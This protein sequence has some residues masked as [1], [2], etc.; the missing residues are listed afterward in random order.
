MIAFF[1]GFIITSL[2]FFFLPQESSRI[3]SIVHLVQVEGWEWCKVLSLYRASFA[4]FEEE[5]F[6]VLYME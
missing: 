4:R 2:L 6:A 5:F 3:S 1:V